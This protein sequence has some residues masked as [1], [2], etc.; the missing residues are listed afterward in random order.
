M[1]KQLPVILTVFLVL[2]ISVLAFTHKRIGNISPLVSSDITKSGVCP[3]FFLYDEDGNIINP[4]KGINADKP[5]SPR[6]TCSKCH[7][8]D[9]ITQGFHFQQGKGEDPDSVMKA[10]F[11]WVSTPGNYGGNWCSPAPIYRALA[12]KNNQSAKEIDMTSF[13]FITATCGNCHPGGGSLEFD[14]NGKRYDKFM[15]DSTNHLTAF[16]NNNF[17]G[18]YYKANW[19]NTG[20]IEVD[21]QL[22]HLPEY[23]YKERNNQIAKLNFKWAATQGSGLATVSGS[24]KDTVP[25]ALNYDLSKFDTEGKLSLHLVREP[26]NE[27]CLN[28][29]AK[30]DWKKK[31]TTY[32]AR[33]DVHLNAGLRCVDCHTAGSMA[34]NERIR[35]KE[36]HQFGKGDDPS[37]NVRNDLDNTVRNCQDCHLTGS[38]NAPI[39]KHSWLPPMHLEKIACQ[40]CHIPERPVKAALVQVSDVYNP[41]TKI[42]P[43]GKYIWTFYDQHLKYWNHYGELEMFTAKDQPTDPFTPSLAEYKGKIYPVNMV[44]SAWPGIYTEGKPGLNQPKM[45]DIYQM[46]T[47]HRKDKAVYPE[48]SKITDNNG[49]SIP[50]VNSVVE[51]DAFIQSVTAHMKFK[52]Y[53][54]TG[55]QIVWVNND[56][57]YLNGRDYKMLDKETYEASPYASVHKFSHDVAPAQA[58]LGRNGCTDC[59]SFNST[60]FFASTLKYPFGENG[61]PVTEPQYKRL[62][63]S[64]FMVYAGAFRESLV[65]PFF[66]FTLVAFLVFILMNLLTANLF[67]NKIISVRQQKLVTWLVSLGI[68]GAGI[69]GYF[70]GDLGNY[71]FPTRIFLDSNHFLISAAVLLAGVWF[72][73]KYQLSST[74]SFRFGLFSILILIAFISGILMLIKLDFISILNRLAYTIYDLSLIGILIMNIFYLE[75]SFE[76]TSAKE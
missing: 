54:L 75:K 6:Q 35:G 66:Y 22:C 24:V 27:T 51:I 50:E 19:K 14:R 42:S 76:N 44:H 7:D 9:K 72:Y 28:C 38:M 39:A 60:F 18:D 68:L 48:L 4:T 12:A 73:L 33:S 29:H 5:Y 15:A 17:D 21:C 30:P 11:Q 31:G 67:S 69:F 56:R 2:I 40:T 58:A 59:H 37:G 52:G 65:K 41:G 3:P 36:V 55:K 47:M 34:S 57:M 70:A 13:D 43:P 61:Q 26:R 25:V 74:K 8:Y 20:I 32:S 71:M 16:G 53:D 63:D 49:D 45:S 1:K 62:N 46:W 10:R 23:N 64:G